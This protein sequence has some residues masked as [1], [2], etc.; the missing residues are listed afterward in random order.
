ME[1]PFPDRYVYIIEIKITIVIIL[2][3][4]IG[5]IIYMIRNLKRYD[6]YKETFFWISFG[7]FTVA[8][9]V[10]YNSLELGLWDKDTVLAFLSLIHFNTE[11]TYPGEIVSRYVAICGYSIIIW[12]LFNLIIVKIN[13][14][15]FSH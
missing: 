6:S 3:I 9:A 8:L 15:K 4:L 1:T 7:L 2:F 13:R 11:V 14:N 10:I 12:G 5:G